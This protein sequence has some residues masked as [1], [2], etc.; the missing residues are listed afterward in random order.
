VNGLTNVNFAQLLS[1]IQVQ[2]AFMNEFIPERNRTSASFA[3][4]YFHHPV[5][6]ANMKKLTLAR[7]PIAASTV[8]KALSLGTAWLNI[9]ELIQ[10]NDLIPVK[11]AASLF[12]LY[13]HCETMKE[14]TYTDS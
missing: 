9:F 4:H 1:P 3:T 13:Q 8:V 5:P 6:E 12:Q 7:S 2:R 14:D 10:K 11:S